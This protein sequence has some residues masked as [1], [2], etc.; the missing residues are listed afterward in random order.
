MTESSS[1][2]NCEF[3]PSASILGRVV[4]RIVQIAVAAV[5]LLAT[6]TPLLELC[7]SWD[8]GV[9]PANDT[10]L[11]VTATFSCI[12]LLATI[13]MLARWKPGAVRTE[14]RSFDSL[15]P[16]QPEHPTTTEP[17]EPTGSPPLLL[18]LRI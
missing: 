11:T 9:V 7:D 3:A 2:K 15:S 8:R 14:N 12:G 17:I 5:L 1:P 18:P 16:R 6:L 10:E 4:R 13:T